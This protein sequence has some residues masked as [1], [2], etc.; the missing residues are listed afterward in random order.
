MKNIR[1]DFLPVILGSDEGAY[2]CARLFYDGCGA[3]ALIVAAE[4][5]PATSHSR[6]L[7]RKIIP[8]LDNHTVFRTEI[9]RLLKKL[10]CDFPKIILVPCSAEFS[11]LLYRNAPK[12]SKYI[13]N[14]L[15]PPEVYSKLRNKRSFFSICET[16]G[17]SHPDYLISPPSG[18][19]SR[20][21][22]FEFP[23][24]LSPV[25]C[26]AS[27]FQSYPIKN[28]KRLYVCYNRADFISVIDSFLA[29]GYN[30]PV[31][32]RHF[33][34]DPD[35]LRIVTAY[36]G[37]NGKVRLVGVGKPI[38]KKPPEGDNQYRQFCALLTVRDRKL[39]DTAADFIERT[40]YRGFVSMPAEIDAESGEYLFSGFYP[41]L[42]G[43][44]Y[45]IHTAGKNLARCLVEDAIDLLPF[46][47]REYAE[48]AGLWSD[49][50]FSGLC[51]YTGI[52]FK[53]SPDSAFS[54]SFDI[55]PARLLTVYKIKNRA[56]N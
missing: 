33:A 11:D 38:Y 6:I 44:S 41:Y 49:L 47:K 27:G 9:P 56:L 36:C 4:A 30:E 26:A 23:C 24:V 2:G 35:N 19:C 14:P 42:S 10:R 34:G 51:R 31:S 18:L 48:D 22:P 7:F 52:R 16:L 17:F 1:R 50:T 13:V 54:Y 53:E 43:A 21:L 32:V 37:R 8:G 20:T 5:N 3:E 40:G 55:S 25:N 46:Q 12:I 29:A 45:H 15:S 39:C 28:K